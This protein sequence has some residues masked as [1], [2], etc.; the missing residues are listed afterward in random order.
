[1][2]TLCGHGRPIALGTLQKSQKS[3]NRRF[4]QSEQYA[5]LESQKLRFWSIQAARSRASSRL[6]PA[7]SRGV[8]RVPEV[9]ES[10]KVAILATSGHSGTSAPKGRLGPPE[11]TEKPRKAGKDE[12]TGKHRSE[13]YQGQSVD[14]GHIAWPRL[15]PA[16]VGP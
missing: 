15:P 10:P 3:E 4:P 9:T 16:I 13:G 5:G 7:G 8:P 12:N 6:E 14:R 1:M 2:A 11:F